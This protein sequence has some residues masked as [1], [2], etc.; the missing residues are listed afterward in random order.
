LLPMLKSNKS[1]QVEASRDRVFTG[2]ERHTNMRSGGVGYPMRAVRSR[3][4]LYIR[5][6]EPDRWPSGDPPNFGDI[7]NGLSKEF[8]I[9]NKGSEKFRKFYEL[10]CT[11]RPAEELYDLRRDPEQQ[12]NVATDPKYAAARERQSKILH[13]YLMQTGDPRATG[14]AV[15]WDSSP[16]YGN[17][18]S[19]SRK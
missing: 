19:Q 9:T 6:Y 5:N 10:S 16:Y 18:N 1:G 4:F 17:A 15:I 13:T 3:D 7:D 11:K 8:V 12:L 2:R 14:R